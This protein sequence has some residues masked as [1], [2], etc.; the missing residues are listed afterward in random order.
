M[1]RFLNFWK[2]TL[3]GPL[4]SVHYSHQRLPDRAQ[5]MRRVDGEF[6]LH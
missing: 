1:H 2:A 3:D 5:R 4:Y 6:K